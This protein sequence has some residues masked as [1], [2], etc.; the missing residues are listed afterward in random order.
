MKKLRIVGRGFGWE[1]AHEAFS[2]RPPIPVDMIVA[3]THVHVCRE[4]LGFVHRSRTIFCRP[5]PW[6][7]DSHSSLY[8]VR[9]DISGFPKGVTCA[10]KPILMKRCLCVASAGGYSDCSHDWNR[11]MYVG[12]PVSTYVRSPAA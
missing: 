11:R 7:Y 9:T 2:R 12:H 4:S 3:R 1:I 6:R 8:D 10:P 5:V